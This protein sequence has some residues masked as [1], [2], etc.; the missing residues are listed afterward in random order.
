MQQLPSI[1]GIENAITI[2]IPVFPMLLLPFLNISQHQEEVASYSHS[3]RGRR[4]QR[5]YLKAP[6]WHPRTRQEMD[7]TQ[8]NIL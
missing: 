5:M 6:L 8:S 1:S 3:P 4:E 7:P 2:S